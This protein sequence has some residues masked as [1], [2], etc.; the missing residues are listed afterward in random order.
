ML[1]SKIKCIVIIINSIKYEIQYIKF[2]KMLLLNKI[3]NI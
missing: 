1:A 2:S 3:Q